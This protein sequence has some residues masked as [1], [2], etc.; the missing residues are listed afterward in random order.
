VVVREQ[1]RH[2]LQ[3]ALDLGK[4]RGRVAWI[5]HQRPRRHRWPRIQM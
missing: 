2:R 5:D 3:A 1:D 4:H